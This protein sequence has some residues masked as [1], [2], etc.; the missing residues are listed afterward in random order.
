MVEMQT[1]DTKYANFLSSTLLSFSL[2]LSTSLESSDCGRL[3]SNQNPVESV[4]ERT[5]RE[6]CMIKVALLIAIISQDV[7]V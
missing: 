4:S 5:E 1:K 7:Y 2:S 3:L 6:Y